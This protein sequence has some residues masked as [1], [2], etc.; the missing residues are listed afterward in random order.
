MGIQEQ[1]K[2]KERGLWKP[3]IDPL[4]GTSRLVKD[5]A[6]NAL[7][8]KLCITHGREQ[9]VYQIRVATGP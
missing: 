2:Q 1:Q 7:F 4:R 8:L 5:G 3:D 6:Q 9:I